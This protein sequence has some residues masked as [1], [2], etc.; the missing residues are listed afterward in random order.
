MSQ[1]DVLRIAGLCIAL[2]GAETLHGIVRTV[3]LARKVGKERATRL[4]VVSGTALA[5]F[6]CYV[7]V[8][9]I[10]LQGWLQHFMLGILLSAFMAGFDITFGRLVM[11]FNWRRI[12]RD[13]NPSSG[14]YL[15]I[16]LV[17]LS[18]IPLAVWSLRTTSQQ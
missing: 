12:W 8:P 9:G 18:V 14:N 13:F 17:A 7:L 3:W 11:R 15:S 4:S 6:V 16:G 2:A 5:F 10:G 1:P